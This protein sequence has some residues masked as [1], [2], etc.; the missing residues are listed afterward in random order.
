[1]ETALLFVTSRLTYVGDIQQFLPHL[2]FNGFKFDP[3]DPRHTIPLRAMQVQLRDYLP[4][5]IPSLQEE[6]KV[7]FRIELPD[8]ESSGEGISLSN[9]SC[10]YHANLK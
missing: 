10:T 6:T 7:V 5:L 2:I 4:S 1:L 9:V 3:K 8:T